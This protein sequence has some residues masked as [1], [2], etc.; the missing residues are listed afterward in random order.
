MAFAQYN[1]K[2]TEKNTNKKSCVLS[3]VLMLLLNGTTHASLS[4]SDAEKRTIVRTR[5]HNNGRLE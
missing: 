5:A 1:Y 4:N 2:T 3:Y